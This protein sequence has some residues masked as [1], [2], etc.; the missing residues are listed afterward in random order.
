MF[1]KIRLLHGSSALVQYNETA[2]Q[3]LFVQSYKKAGVESRIKVHLARH[4]LGYHQEKMGYAGSTSESKNLQLTQDSYS[5]QADQ[6]SKLGWSRDTYMNTYAPSLPK[7]VRL[8]SPTK[9]YQPLPI[10]M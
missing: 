7:Q 5:V 6:T 1:L 10:N 4:M 9:F 2:L 8:L 3:N